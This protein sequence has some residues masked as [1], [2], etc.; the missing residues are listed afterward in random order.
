MKTDRR[1]DM[2]AATPPNEGKRML[3]SLAVTEAE[4]T[5]EA[6]AQAV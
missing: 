3:F 2:F 4:G 1:F 5:G 6:T